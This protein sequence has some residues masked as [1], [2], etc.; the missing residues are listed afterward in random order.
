MKRLPTKAEFKALLKLTHKWDEERNGLLVTADNWNELFFP[1]LGC[2]YNA[3]VYNVYYSGYYLSA[4]PSES[5]SDEPVDYER[6]QRIMMY[7][8]HMS[9]DTYHKALCV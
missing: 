3:G 8:S 9:D 6:L 5:H 1:A 4:T 2:K 7:K